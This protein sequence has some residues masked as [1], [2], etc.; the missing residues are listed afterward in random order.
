MIFIEPTAATLP[1]RPSDYFTTHRS[2]DLQSRV[3][4]IEGIL[5]PLLF[6]VSFLQN[7][8]EH[9]VEASFRL[10]F[11]VAHVILPLR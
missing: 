3:A 5:C 7:C 6:C 2:S 10:W 4:T 11:K 8:A 1:I 9:M